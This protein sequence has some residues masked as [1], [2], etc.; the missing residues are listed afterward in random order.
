MKSWAGIALSSLSGKFYKNVP[1]ASV[2][3][4]INESADKVSQSHSQP[5]NSRN[6]CITPIETDSKNEDPFEDAFNSLSPS[7]NSSATPS[8]TPSHPKQE[9][10]QQDKSCGKPA[11]KPLVLKKTVSK[12]DPFAE[13]DWGDLDNSFNSSMSLKSKSTKEE[14]APPKQTF[15]VKQTNND[16]NQSDGDW[17]TNW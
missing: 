7:R 5:S 6:N 4:T 1:Q 15:E 2:P 13:D 16:G 8:P 12:K 11:K 10:I 9:K 14:K 3:N 17:D